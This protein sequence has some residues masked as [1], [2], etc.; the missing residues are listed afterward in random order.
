MTP[1]EHELLERAEDACADPRH[2]KREAA[3]WAYWSAMRR[4]ASVTQT[5]DLDAHR[6]WISGSF[7]DG[8]NQALAECALPALV[9]LARRLDAQVEALTRE[10]DEARARLHDGADLWETLRREMATDLAS[11]HASRDAVVE[12]LEGERDRLM[13]YAT[14]PAAD[15][16]AD[17]CPACEYREGVFVQAC[18]IHA[19]EAER[20]SLR[21]AGDG[22]VAAVEDRC[23]IFAE[24]ADAFDA[25]PEK[26]QDMISKTV[27][28]RSAAKYVRA[29]LAAWPP[30]GPAPE[31]KCPECHGRGFV[32]VSGMANVEGLTCPRCGGRGS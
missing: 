21:A 6:G 27:A 30:S 31:A 19:A 29:A 7:D 16:R 28:F 3:S 23:A 32:S 10:R 2:V 11:L 25:T 5:I 12:A 20:D 17:G 13:A 18:R 14:D 9:A 4:G 1:E 24:I 26:S 22:L 8:W 15:L